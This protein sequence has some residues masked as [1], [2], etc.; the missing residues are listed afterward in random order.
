MAV[1]S[2]EPELTLYLT[3]VGVH[4]Q[5][6][7]MGK[8]SRLAIPVTSRDRCLSDLSRSFGR[9][10][11]EN[12]IAYR[13]DNPRYIYYA[14]ARQVYGSRS[15]TMA[16]LLQSVDFDEEF[17]YQDFTTL[18]KIVCGLDFRD[19][20]SEAELYPHYINKVDRY[21]RNALWYSVIHEAPHFVHCLLKRGADL[22]GMS[23]IVHAVRCGSPRILELLITPGTPSQDF[24]IENIRIAWWWSSRWG[25]WGLAAQEHQ[26]RCSSI[27]LLMIKHLVDVN[28]QSRDGITMLMDMCQWMRPCAGR[29][30][31]LIRNGADPEI[32]D[33]EGWTALLHTFHMLDAEAFQTLVRAGARL[34]VRTHSGFTILHIAVLSTSSL[35]DTINIVEAMRDVD[36]RGLDLD[37]RDED[38][39]TAFDLLKKRNG[40]SWESYC[41][42]KKRLLG[43]LRF[44]LPVQRDHH[45]VDIIRSLESLFHHIQDSQGI[46]LEQQYPPLADYLCENPDEDVV[47]GAWPV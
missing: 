21:G 2:G 1:E 47:P 19:L 40:I 6:P 46:P 5:T 25:Y 4:S 27:E 38:G 34:D 26:R 16:Q 17:E 20:D 45:E 41:E 28:W 43:P 22:G 42:G 14:V 29:I 8:S 36:L 30:E 35:R 33:E 3:A 32:S 13:Y 7:I 37:A 11:W 10:L 12:Y 15:A 23:M 31:Q 9:L 39:C 44:I 24:D 18:H